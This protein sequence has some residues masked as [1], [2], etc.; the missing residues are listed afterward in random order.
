MARLAAALL[1]CAALTAKAQIYA[2]DAKPIPK[3]QT[4]NTLY[5]FYVYSLHEAPDRSVGKPFVKINGVAAS[6]MPGAAE[7][8]SKGYEGLQLSLMRYKDFWDLIDP[9]KFCTTENDVSLGLAK[10]TGE[11][12]LNKSPDLSLRDVNVISYTVPMMSK[13]NEDWTKP[14]TTYI[15]STGVYILVFSNCGTK[16]QATVSGTLAV[17]NAYGFLPGNEYHKMPFYGWLLLVYMGLAF[18]W[19]SISLKWWRELFAIH[20]C[21]S[22][23]IFL[24]LLECF[25]WYLFFNDWNAKGLRP[26]FLFV[27]STLITVVKT[28][29][30][31]LL[32][33]VASLGWGVTR[34]YLDTKVVLNLQVLGL[35][36]I[37]LDFIKETVFSYRNSHSFPHAFVVLSLL[38]VSLLN[39]AIFSWVFAALSSLMETLQERRQFEKLALFQNL[40]KILVGAL[41][42]ATCTLLFKLFNRSRSISFW[43]KYEWFI[44]DGVSHI[45]FLFVL[46]AIMYLWAPNK[47]SQRYAYSQQVRGEEEMGGQATEDHPGA[48]WADDDAADE[49]NE[50]DSFWATTKGAAEG[51]GPVDVIGSAS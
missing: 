44:A 31:Y 13:D 1:S 43:W 2:F 23:V 47:Y 48:I 9:N 29:F 28:T 33:L 7:P 32:V 49:E 19:M 30:S 4:L 45:V 5:A 40:W 34:P 41:A 22:S 51:K 16:T 10:K 18:V 50:G 6:M 8:D 37:L 3:N 26:T 39:G 15:D 46:L 38:P 35:L 36:Y 42:I 11:L 27:I 17:K 14:I 12:L 20:H 24:G 25:M 21:I